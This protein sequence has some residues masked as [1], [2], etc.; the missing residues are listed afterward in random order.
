VPIHNVRDVKYVYG[1]LKMYGVPGTLSGGINVRGSGL[2]ATTLKTL[3]VSSGTSTTSGKPSS[4]NSASSY[5]SR[6]EILKGSIGSEKSTED[7]TYP[8]QGLHIPETSECLL[9]ITPSRSHRVYIGVPSH[10]GASSTIVAGNDIERNSS[11]NDSATSTPSPPL[12]NPDGTS[13][14]ESSKPNRQMQKHAIAAGGSARAAALLLSPEGGPGTPHLGSGKRKRQRPRQGSRRGQQVR[15]GDRRLH[16]ISDTLHENGEDLPVSSLQSDNDNI[17]SQAKFSDV[18]Y[19]IITA[20]WP[21]PISLVEF[22]QKLAVSSNTSDLLTGNSYIQ[23]AY[24]SSVTNLL[25]MDW[26]GPIRE[27]MGARSRNSTSLIAELLGMRKNNASE[28]SFSSLTSTSA[29]VPSDY[30]IE[31]F[32]D[33]IFD[34]E[35]YAVDNPRQLQGINTLDSEDV[36]LMHDAEIKQ[37]HHV[38]STHGTGKT[39][40]DEGEDNLFVLRDHL[41]LLPTDSFMKAVHRKATDSVVSNIGTKNQQSKNQNNIR[42]MAARPY[43]YAERYSLKT[44]S[45]LELLLV[46]VDHSSR[47][48]QLPPHMVNQNKESATAKKLSA[49]MEKAKAKFIPPSSIPGGLGAAT[50]S[51]SFQSFLASTGVSSKWANTIRCTFAFRLLMSPGGHGAEDKVNAMLDEVVGRGSGVQKSGKH[52]KNMK[53]ITSSSGMSTVLPQAVYEKHTKAGNDIR[54]LQGT[55]MGNVVTSA[56][57]YPL[58]SGRGLTSP[59]ATSSIP[60]AHSISKFKHLMNSDQ[61]SIV[62]SF[63]KINVD[64]LESKLATYTFM[65]TII[66]FFQSYLLV[67][68]MYASSNPAAASRISILSISA[69]AVLDAA[70]CILHLLLSSVVSGNAFYYF[71]WLSFLKLVV[72]CILEMRFVISIYQARYAQ[73]MAQN[74][75]TGLRNHLATLHARFY[76]ALFLVILLVDWYYTR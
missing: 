5:A 17:K 38:G 22:A 67:S 25:Y 52:V 66:C 16:V 11:E 10:A 42:T 46:D 53:N 24:T 6:L 47:T 21:L 41:S 60:D 30:D 65:Y 2:P 40:L 4:I 1:I 75:W 59:D 3:N 63:Y 29:V 35:N 23:E 74:G 19:S 73:E 20:V 36:E 31:S 8:V 57:S 72:F 69:M 14:D 33:I 50:M 7:I 62:A 48:Q 43:F 34:R 68:Q 18:F 76:G 70:I 37:G 28:Y 32:N 9:V 15:S 45:G 49:Q 26:T 61:F 64:V 56:C 71:L 13:R 27:A 12:L 51:N 58:C 39:A 55:L 44:V 54:Q